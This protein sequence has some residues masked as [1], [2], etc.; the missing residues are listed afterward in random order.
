[1]EQNIIEAGFEKVWRMFQETD[2]KFQETDR[3]CKETSMR[4][5]ETDRRF[6]K[7]DREIKETGKLVKE[8]N[9]QIQET[10]KKL[11]EVMEGLKKLEDTFI[12][13]W[14]RFMEVLVN[15]GAILALRGAGFSINHSAKN[16][17]EQMPN[18]RGRGMEIDVLCWGEDIV[19]PI[20]VKTTLKVEDVDE[21][22]EKLGRF[23]ECF[24]NFRGM[25]LYGAVAGLDFAGGSNRYAYKKGLYVLTL[26]GDRVVEV[27]NDGKFRPKIWG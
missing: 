21:H 1:M 8:T 7:T 6:K 12:T 4:F 16:V 19:V 9:I 11:K 17:T 20:E 14:G 13:R 23:F 24:P 22:I 2:R 18:G 10:D 26:K 5:K 25:K 27:V 3:R 15:S